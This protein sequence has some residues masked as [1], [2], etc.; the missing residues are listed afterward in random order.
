M[1]YRKKK[2]KKNDGANAVDSVPLRV[3]PTIIIYTHGNPP[4]LTKSPV[5]ICIRCRRFALDAG[6]SRE[7]G[8]Y[9]K[10]VI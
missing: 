6:G 9:S 4:N 3:R 8:Q 5:N 2:K 1:K 10:N 7:R